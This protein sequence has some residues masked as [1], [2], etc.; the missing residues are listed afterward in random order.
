MRH[1]THQLRRLEPW[2][3]FFRVV[4]Y[5]IRQT[6]DSEG[7]R[8]AA[9]KCYTALATWL[10]ATPNIA[11]FIHQTITTCVQSLPLSFF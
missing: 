4:N 10:S 5:Q 2:V 11:V 8:G 6:L 9:R 7:L 1:S 3:H